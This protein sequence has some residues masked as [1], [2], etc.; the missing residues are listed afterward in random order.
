MAARRAADGVNTPWMDAD[1]VA[2]Y[3]RLK[4]KTVQNLTGPNVPDPIPFHRIAAGGQKRFHR[5]QVDAWLTAK[6][7]SV[8]LPSANGAASA[9]T[10]PPPDKRS[11]PHAS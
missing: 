11:D 1:E 9:D 6:N 3:L 2:D 4:P 5:D 8:S 10:D 7:L